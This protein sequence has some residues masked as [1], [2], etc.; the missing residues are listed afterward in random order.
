MTP[1]TKKWDGIVDY[2]AWKEWQTCPAGW[3]EKY[4]NY[5]QRPF[6]P[7]LRDDALCLGSLVHEGLRVWQSTHT[8]EI[9]QGVVEEVTPS[10]EAL[11][12]AHELVLG[13]ARVYPEE[14]WP[15][16][17]C[18][19]P[20]LFPLLPSLVGLAK[21]DAYFYVPEPYIIESG[22]P[23]LQFTLTPG[24]WVHE[25]KTKSSDVSLP[26]FIQKWEMNMQASFQVLA[27][28]SRIR[29]VAQKLDYDHHS[30]PISE[31]QG[32][33]VNVLEKPKK[34]IPQRTCKA[35]KTKQ[36]YA[37]YLPTGDGA[38]CCPTCGAAQKLEP[39][40]ENPTVRPPAYYRVVV[41][42]AP[43]Q[44]AKAQRDIIQVGER[45]ARMAEE[46][47][48]SEEWNT[49]SCTQYKRPCQ[50]FSNHFSGDSTLTDITMAK[51]GDYRGLKEGD[52]NDR[53]TT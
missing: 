37:T 31:V 39:L 40:K 15:L 11:T 19:E 18:E 12:L 1:T 3:Y 25:Y 8:I 28:T 6:P 36:E 42:R 17:L 21:L 24:W 45:M 9:P 34:Y 10:P 44:L 33:L 48:E 2:S 53:R 14:R 23:G 13:Y 32:V 27:L 20:L 49:E 35:C 26:L 38:F 52:C 29:E 51:V 5:R 43:R 7:A 22:Q 30:F 4:I 50:Y 47:L 41:H 46:G 16:I